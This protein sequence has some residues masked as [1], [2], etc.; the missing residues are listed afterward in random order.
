MTSTS[1]FSNFIDNQRWALYHVILE[2][3]KNGK[4]LKEENERRSKPVCSVRKHFQEFGIVKERVWRKQLL[5]QMGKV[6]K[7]GI[8]D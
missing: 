4:F 6:V 8:S 1:A 5:L 2:K 7:N 3:S